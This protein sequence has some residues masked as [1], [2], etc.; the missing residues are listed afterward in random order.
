M[1]TAARVSFLFAVAVLATACADDT[2][3]APADGGSDPG[4]EADSEVGPQ[5][6]PS[7]SDSDDAG[8]ASETEQ[9]DAATSSASIV[10]EASDPA[11]AS[12][13]YP[14][15]IYAEDGGPANLRRKQL[16]LTL[17]AKID[18]STARAV[19]SG[20]GDEGRSLSAAP[21]HDGKE[22]VFDV[23][24]LY[25]EGSAPTPLLYDTP[26]ELDLSALRSEDG[27]E[28]AEATPGRRLLFRT[29]PADSLVEHT[30]GHTADDY[31]AQLTASA[32]AG[33]APLV[34]LAH[35]RYGLTIPGDP[36]PHYLAIQVPRTAQP[37]PWEY[38][39]FAGEAPAPTV[40][41]PDGSEIAV[42]P[43]PVPAV[44]AS[45]GTAYVFTLEE[46]VRYSLA[47]DAGAPLS[48]DLF[49]ERQSA[50]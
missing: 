21:S 3:S 22:L 5:D 33:S 41:A 19:L 35:R 40:L 49:F 24:L 48:T 46:G 25:P 20:P 30:C 44:C 42:A 10:I 29:A 28:L 26:Y 6:G 2:S 45:I 9:R 8:R 15:E 50:E 31:Y 39:L 7:S 47:Y 38:T 18:P 11:H 17:S 34:G 43:R 12:V 4:L 32:D 14:F 27:R 13:T 1:T 36:A 16:V 23:P 37:K